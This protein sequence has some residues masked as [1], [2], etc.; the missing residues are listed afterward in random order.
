MLDLGEQ[1]DRQ[2]RRPSQIEKVVLDAHLLEPQQVGP[3]L[4][5][6]R[7]DFVSGREEGMPRPRGGVAVSGPSLEK[8]EYLTG[9]RQS[10]GDS[11]EPLAFCLWIEQRAGRHGRGRGWGRFGLGLSRLG[12]IG[13][14]GGRLR[15]NTIMPAPFDLVPEIGDDT[16]E[17]LRAPAGSSGWRSRL[18]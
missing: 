13:D 6:R 14:R 5:Q 17:E 2:E 16:I 15:G 1:V 4:G 10:G 12:S 3:D 8:L 11:L 7:F 9:R 18:R